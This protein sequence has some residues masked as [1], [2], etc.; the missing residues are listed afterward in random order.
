MKVRWAAI[1]A[2]LGALAVLTGAF[3]SHGLRHYDE[4]VRHTWEIAAR[5]HSY[6]VLALFG[7]GLSGR[8]GWPAWL[9][10]AGILLFSGSLY[11]LALTG[12]K[13]LAWVTPVGGSLWVVAWLAAA[14]VLWRSR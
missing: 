1:A 6:H 5:Y 12:F 3:G 8:G 14:G 11:G 10:L 13:P 4:A 9:W 7:W 2:I